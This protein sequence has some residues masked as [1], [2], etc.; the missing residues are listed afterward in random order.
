MRTTPLTLDLKAFGD[1]I[2]NLRA[3]LKQDIGDKD[4]DQFRNNSLEIK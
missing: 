3:E 4:L 2:D 1:D